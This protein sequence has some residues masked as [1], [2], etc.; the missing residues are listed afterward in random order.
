MRNASIGHRK[1]R[2]VGPGGSV[3]RSTA[4]ILLAGV[5]TV[6]AAGACSSTSKPSSSNGGSASQAATKTPYEIAM[7]DDI[8]GGNSSNGAQT[9]AGTT[10][11]VYAI[12]AAGGVN[13]HPL[14]LATLDAQSTAAGAETAFRSAVAD[15]PLA[16]TGAI[17]SVGEQAA[18]AIQISSGIPQV[19]AS[20]PVT[21]LENEPFW[22]SLSPSPTQSATEQ[23]DGLKAV[24]GTLSGKKIALEGLQSP[25]T[26]AIL[27]QAQS[28]ITADGG[29][30]GPVINDPLQFSDWSSQAANV[31][32]AHADAVLIN[33]TGPMTA[34]IAKAL[35]TAGFAGP[36]DSAEAQ[37]SDA[38]FQEVAASNFNAI[39]ETAAPK[40]G[41]AAYTA[42][43]N[44]GGLSLAG[45]G[46]YGKAWASV[47][48]IAAALKSCG[49]QCSSSSIEAGLQGLHNYA[50]P[51]GILLGPINFASGHEGLTSFQLYS[52]NQSSGA[53]APKGSVVSF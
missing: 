20:Y 26:D 8:T 3:S 10:A 29:S 2:A 39:R 46:F 23:V 22:Y 17:S 41:T 50:V 53:A 37:S 11:A 43:K 34:L 33:H 45:T 6:I 32:A 35:V 44:T 48:A 52:W 42:A 5:I 36:I 13:G 51:G 14:K 49:S 30:V 24:L 16:I 1:P 27:A 18:A 9:Q 40:P 12:N 47:Y 21:A 28:V 4:S 31:K 25:A 15:N 19:V 7:V 38:L